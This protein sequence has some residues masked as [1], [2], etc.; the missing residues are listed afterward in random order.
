VLKRS[1]ESILAVREALDSNSNPGWSERTQSTRLSLA[2]NSLRGVYYAMW[3]PPS[4]TE[5]EKKKK[6]YC[7]EAA[8]ARLTGGGGGGWQGGASGRRSWQSSVS[9]GLLFWPTICCYS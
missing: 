1:V 5:K 8:G 3:E 4:K 2:T 9:D 7:L 6:V